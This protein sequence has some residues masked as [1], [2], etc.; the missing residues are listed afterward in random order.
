M[1]NVNVAKIGVY[2]IEAQQEQ[3]HNK[4]ATRTCMHATKAQQKQVN[5]Q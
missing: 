1:H 2:V 5:I 4:G 3:V